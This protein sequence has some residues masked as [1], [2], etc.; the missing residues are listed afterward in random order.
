[1]SPRQQT[2][3]FEVM[4]PL[5]LSN[6]AILKIAKAWDLSADDAR[7]LLGGMST[8]SFYSLTKGTVRKLDQDPLTRVSLVIGI[9]KALN[10]LYST[11]LADQWISLPNSNPMFG[12]ETPLQYMQQGGIPAMVRVRQ[13]LD[14]R[15]G[16]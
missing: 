16:R 1:M 5:D 14:A 7:L 3:H 9:F 8:G 4:R 13:L 2:E 10:M 12:G 6:R 15:R 11:K